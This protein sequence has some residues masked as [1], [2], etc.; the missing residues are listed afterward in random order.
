MSGDPLEST[1]GLKPGDVVQYSLHL[2]SRQTGEMYWHT[3]FAAVTQVIGRRSLE[4][5]TL[6]LNP[7]PKYEPR[8]LRIGDPATV[9]T[10]LPED[11]WPQGVM[12][13]RMKHIM[14][15]TIKLGDVE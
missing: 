1:E 13:T 11:Q 9:V 10:F 5:L 6:V 8:Q 14:T 2:R 3:R 4:V 12:A 7:D 15:G